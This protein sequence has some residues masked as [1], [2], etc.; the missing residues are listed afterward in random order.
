VE[1]GFQT[2]QDR[3][4]KGMRVAKV[5]TLEQAN[6]Y[7]AAEFLA[8]WNQTLTVA[9]ANTE[10]AHRELHTHHNLT[11]ILSHVETRQVSNDYTIQFDSQRY[12][13]Q[14]E[15]IRTG[16]RG[17]GVRVEKRLDGS[18]AA[19]FGEDYLELMLCSSAAS[20]ARPA[21]PGPAVR[22]RTGPNAGGQ[23]QW[24][25]HF[26]QQP[27]P[28]LWKVLQE[29]DASEEPEAKRSAGPTTPGRRRV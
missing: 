29:I 3:L 6:R 20:V 11:G 7:L 18:V 27:G 24:M 16:L 8:W 1:R 17:S 22:P 23:S 26:G 13:I 15:S 9:A 28:P 10:D 25:K 5:N 14:R 19:R 21:K 2:A 4:I 12:Q